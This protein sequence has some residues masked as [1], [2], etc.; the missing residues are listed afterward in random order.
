MSRRIRFVGRVASMEEKRN[1]YKVLVGN[2][3]E[4]ATRKI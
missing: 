4:D 3:K 1:G 2:Q